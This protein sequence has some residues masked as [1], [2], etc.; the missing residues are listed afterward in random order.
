MVDTPSPQGDV[1]AEIDNG[2]EE[3]PEDAAGY[4]PQ[5][6]DHDANSNSVA[7]LVTGSPQANGVVPVRGMAVPEGLCG[8]GRVNSGEQVSYDV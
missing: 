5:S 6:Q 8:D 1:P 2:D 4:T 3:T 7:T